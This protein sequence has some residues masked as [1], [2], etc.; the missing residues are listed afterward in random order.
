MIGWLSDW[1]R[2]IITVILLAVLVELLLPNKAMQRYAR[3]VV[4]LFILLTILSPILRLL[5]TDIGNRLDAGVEIWNERS[6]NKNVEMPSLE[7]I[8]RRASDIQTK[9]HEEAA[10]LTAAA[11]EEA[12]G[13]AIASETGAR[14]ETVNV[15][16]TWN[17]RNKEGNTPEIAGVTVTLA[18]SAHSKDT[19]SNKLQTPIEIEV[20][21]PVDVSVGAGSASKP[22]DIKPEKNGYSP[23]SKTEAAAVQSVL[24]RGWGV[25]ANRVDIRIRAEGGAS[26]Q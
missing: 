10:R 7:E 20:I 1:L 15:S 21:A 3:L 26:G 17:E 2:D 5:Q 18:G 12:M 11:L 9:R 25:Q 6:M 19:K 24:A 13:K 8:Q 22:T 23:P 14:V 16:L 4:G